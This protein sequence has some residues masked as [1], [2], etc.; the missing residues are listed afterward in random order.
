MFPSWPHQV[1]IVFVSELPKN[2]DTIE[3]IAGS[4]VLTKFWYITTW[5]ANKPT[6]VLM[7]K[8]WIDTFLSKLP[9]QQ[10]AQITVK[11][12]TFC[13]VVWLMII[14]KWNQSLYINVLIFWKNFKQIVSKTW[15]MM[16]T[17]FFN[18][19]KLVARGISLYQKNGRLTWRKYT[20][21][22]P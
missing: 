10:V 7:L 15:E 13:L 5:F 19:K 18:D 20:F 16:E 22:S 6:P 3:R 1:T 12:K 9:P 8:F 14:V 21:K 17:T 11:Q 2:S 4:I